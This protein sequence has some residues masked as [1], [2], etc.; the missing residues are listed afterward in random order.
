M[1]ITKKK[2][3]RSQAEYVVYYDEWTGEVLTIGSSEQEDNANPFIKTKNTDAKRVIDGTLDIN[4]LI[5]SSDLNKEEELVLKSEV[6]QI[7]RQ[8]DN[9][10]L[11]PKRPLMYWDICVKLYT[12]NR[13]I[14]IEVN[15]ETLQR[16]ITFN[17]RNEIQVASPASLDFYITKQD[18]P[19][20][21]IEILK[22]DATDLIKNKCIVFDATD[23][24][25][26]AEIEKIDI[27]TQ[28]RFENYYFEVIADKYVEET[29]ELIVNGKIWQAADDR[30]PSHF[31]IVQNGNKLSITSAIGI[32]QLC[33]YGIYSRFMPFY[34][35][36]GSPDEYITSFNV[37]IAT[38]RTGKADVFEIDF[39]ID[40]VNI[41]YKNSKLR[42]NKRK[43][44][45][46]VAD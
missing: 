21:L 24:I 27:F 33:E 26:Y 32:K 2:R 7:R 5:V 11:L 35:V 1:A 31:E 44:D 40:E 41:L 16:L 15:Q 4:D 29:D 17:I 20:H 23:I 37:D 18:V 38:L 39:D 9:L 3:Q 28:R 10:F 30:M 43:I 19:D 25:P 14:V 12:T 6:L 42:V 34:I 8:E 36:K 45:D 13:K 22:V 46:T